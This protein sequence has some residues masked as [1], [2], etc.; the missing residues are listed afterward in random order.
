M[1][2]I[3]TSASP[4]ARAAAANSAWAKK[5]V[6]IAYPCWDRNSCAIKTGKS[7]KSATVVKTTLTRSGPVNSDPWIFVS[8]CVAVWHHPMLPNKLIKTARPRRRVS[9]CKVAKILTNLFA[10]SLF[11]AGID[12]PP[13]SKVVIGTL[14]TYH[15][16]FHIFFE[17][18]SGL[19][20]QMLAFEMISLV[21]TVYFIQNAIAVHWFD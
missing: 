11:V 16:L 14:L 19:K 18:F 10:P 3:P 6:C 8:D 13:L 1:D 20:I 5:V 4:R 12:E 7:P 15:I 2:P 21:I 17:I 9:F